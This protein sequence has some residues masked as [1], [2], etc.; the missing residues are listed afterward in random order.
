MGGFQRR[1][2]KVRGLSLEATFFQKFPKLQIS[3]PLQRR[4][5]G[6]FLINHSRLLI[7]ESVRVHSYSSI[8]MA[9]HNKKFINDPN[10]HDNS[11]LAALHISIFVLHVLFVDLLLNLFLFRGIFSYVWEAWKC[12]RLMH[13]FALFIRITL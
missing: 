8:L 6:R 12:P 4:K 10:G 11:L 2:T 7:A 1:S 9:Y 13:A 3:L 5:S